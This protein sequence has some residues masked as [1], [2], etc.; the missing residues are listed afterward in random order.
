MSVLKAWMGNFPTLISSMLCTGSSNRKGLPPHLKRGYL[1]ALICILK[2]TY[3]YNCWNNAG[4]SFWPAKRRR[5]ASFR[6]IVAY[7][8]DFPS[9]RCTVWKPW[10]ISQVFIQIKYWK[11]WVSRCL[12]S[13][14]GIEAI[15]VAGSYKGGWHGSTFSNL[16]R[17]LSFVYL[18]FHLVICISSLRRALEGIMRSLN[19]LQERFHQS[20]FFYLLPATNRY[21]SIGDLRYLLRLHEVMLIF[22]KGFTCLLWVS[23]WELFY[24]KL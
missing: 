24:Y 21:I 5:M 8:N 20:F 2:K 17:Y 13:R 6:H 15:T 4:R 16:G 7:A 22:W 19:N 1:V 11:P 14:F 23:W 10:L 9:Y 3:S 18:T 12:R